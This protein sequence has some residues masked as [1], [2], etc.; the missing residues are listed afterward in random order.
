[1]LRTVLAV[2]A[3][4]IVT[5]GLVV[6]GTTL[7]AVLLLGTPAAG[8]PPQPTATYL[9]A[10]LL[11]S[12]LAAIGGGFVVGTLARQPTLTPVWAFAAIL[13]LLSLVSALGTGAA[14]G[15]PAWYPLVIAVVGPAGVILGG[16]LQRR[17]G[18]MG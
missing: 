5:A 7:A 2:V 11:V 6:I 1:M 3:G 15:Q 14:A 18:R 13:L 9:A 12:G 16:W 4:F 8:Q 10:N 17:S